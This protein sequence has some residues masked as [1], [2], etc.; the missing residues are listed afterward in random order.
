MAKWEEKWSLRELIGNIYGNIL[1]D[2]CQCVAR[3]LRKT[4]KLVRLS[5]MSILL[6]TRYIS[7]LI[8]VC[9]PKRAKVRDFNNLWFVLGER[10]V[11]CLASITLP[12]P[13]HIWYQKQQQRM[14]EWCYLIFIENLSG[15]NI[16]NTPKDLARNF[17]WQATRKETFYSSWS[18]DKNIRMT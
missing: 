9:L 17:I 1:R 11:W 4:W 18:I 13:S 15:K 8:S 7:F 2:G 14:H 16:F 10:V 6:I 3:L 5:H 12:T